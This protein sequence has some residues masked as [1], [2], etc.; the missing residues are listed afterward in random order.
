MTNQNFRLE[1][2]PWQSKQK[3]SNVICSDSYKHFFLFSLKNPKMS[4]DECCYVP[5]C[6]TCLI[7]TFCTPCTYAMAYNKDPDR[8]KSVCDCSFACTLM[9]LFTC[10]PCFGVFVRTQYADQSCV[11]ACC[12]EWLSIFACAPC[13]MVDYNKNSTSTGTKSGF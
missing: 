5:T 2:K 4:L 10:V 11:K 6:D 13:H 3:N 12:Y 1:F 7:A 8:A 9:S